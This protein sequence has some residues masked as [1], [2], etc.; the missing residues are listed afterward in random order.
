LSPGIVALWALKPTLAL[1]NGGAVVFVREPGLLSG[2]IGLDY[3]VLSG[4]IGHQNTEQVVEDL[5]GSGRFELVRRFHSELSFL[6]V[7]FDITKLPHDIQYPFPDLYL[8]RPSG[9]DNA[10]R[11]SMVIEAES[12]TRGNAPVDHT[13]YGQDIGVIVSAGD[14]IETFAEYEID[15]P[16]PGQYQLELR[17]ASGISRPLY[18][19]VDGALK[20][21]PIAARATGGWFP[22][23]QRWVYAGIFE[24]ADLR[25]ILRIG[26]DR[27]PIPHIDKL[28]ITPR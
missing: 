9:S 12:F 8:L 24:S 5:V 15:L 19:Q 6:G 16:A 21:E 25:C 7:D 4:F 22:D 14:G 26:R 13:N 17:L 3:L 20:G 11:P 2:S 27:E 28:R 10:D 23:S 18:L 1:I